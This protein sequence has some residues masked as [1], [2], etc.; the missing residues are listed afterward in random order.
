MMDGHVPFYPLGLVL[1]FKPR[2][3]VNWNRHSQEVSPGGKVHDICDRLKAGLQTAQTTQL[4]LA[5]TL[6][7]TAIQ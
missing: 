4:H 7:E 6:V 3:Y 2:E 5:D 1:I